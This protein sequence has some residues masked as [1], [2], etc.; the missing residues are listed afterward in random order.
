MK[1]DVDEVRRATPKQV[2]YLE[3]L[4]RN[5]LNIYRLRT[6]DAEYESCMRRETFLWP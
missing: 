6:L 5:G 1:K 2:V 3:F 4:G